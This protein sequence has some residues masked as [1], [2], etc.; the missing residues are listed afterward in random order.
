MSNNLS[1]FHNFKNSLKNKKQLANGDWKITGKVIYNWNGKVL[2]ENLPICVRLVSTSAGK[3][4]LDEGEIINTEQK[5]HME[6]NSNFS[7]PIFSLT[8]E[9][10]LKIRGRSA[11]HLGSVNYDVTIVPL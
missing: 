4:D 3:I 5:I 2:E 11:P 7:N 8:S 9:G 6:F 1:V 10:F